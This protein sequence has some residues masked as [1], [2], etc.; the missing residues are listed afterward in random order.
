MK[1][2][3]HTKNQNYQLDPQGETDLI[4]GSFMLVQSDCNI[5]IHSSKSVELSPPGLQLFLPSED[6]N[7]HQ[8]ENDQYFLFLEGS[9][10]LEHSQTV[11][12]EVNLILLASS[13]SHQPLGNILRQIAGG[14]FNLVIFNKSTDQI[15]IINDRLAILP[16]YWL[17]CDEGLFVTNNQLNLRTRSRLSPSATIEFLKYGYLPVSPALLNNVA[18]LDAD[19]F[20]E[21]SP[22]QT[23][24]RTVR[25]N[26]LPRTVGHEELDT[27][28]DRWESA[29]EAYFSRVDQPVYL[30]LSGGYD[31]RLLAAYGAR[32]GAV[33]L[34]FGE[35]HSAESALA[36]EIASELKLELHRDQFPA[37]ALAQHQHRLKSDFRTPTSLENVH[38]LHLSDQVEQQAPALYL[39]GFLGGAIMGDVYFHQRSSSI[40]G[41]T[42]YL[43]G[44]RSHQT[45]SLSAAQYVDHL[46]YGDKQGLADETLLGLMTPT[47]SKLL[48]QRFSKFVASWRE[49]AFNHEQLVER[50]MLL[51]RGRNLIAN[52]PVSLSTHTQTLIPFLDYGIQDL[53]WETPKRYRFSHA[54]Y[55]RFWRQTFPALA[56]IRKSGTFGR[57]SDGN[58]RYRIKSILFIAYKRYIHPLIQK[59]GK[60]A[61]FG[62]EEYFSTKWYLSDP[63]NQAL[64]KPLMAE[65][66]PQLPQEIEEKIQTA[67]HAGNLHPSLLMR[68]ITLRLML[69]GNQ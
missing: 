55:N 19:H 43:L 60:S 31:S 29:F 12:P 58:L 46:Y 52:G 41:M 25:Q 48:K 67:Y 36:K 54:L 49:E 1:T 47:E 65:V 40:G 14:M 15:H 3:I 20:L 2:E 5:E 39:D 6:S 23:E 37:N 30:G 18:R 59:L 22:F 69:K 11:E 28:V 51:S 61:N 33:A 10:Y 16:L 56:G 45:K 32:K 9:F 26:T 68:Y 8:F 57:P 17:T 27:Y 64:L 66:E 7:F 42:S 62:E 13:L 38:V 34:N 35:E 24:V 44:L 21:I 50:F 63:E 53:S 4:P